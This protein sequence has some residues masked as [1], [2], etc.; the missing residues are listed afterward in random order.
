MNRMALLALLGIAT[1]NPGVFA[2]ADQPD[3]SVPLCRRPP[4]GIDGQTES[5]R[6]I[7]YPCHPLPGM[8]PMVPPPA[9]PPV[10]AARPYSPS[11]TPVRMDPKHPLKIGLLYYPDAAKRAHEEGRCIVLITVS[12]EGRITA[13]YLQ[14]SGGYP[15]LDQAC[16]KAVADQRMLPATENGRPIEKTLSIPI[17]WKLPLLTEGPLSH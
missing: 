17:V 3:S 12:V 5:D 11:T 1:L 16:L 9:L 10:V 13:A 4:T 14:T 15:R 2:R 6:S 8:P 7:V